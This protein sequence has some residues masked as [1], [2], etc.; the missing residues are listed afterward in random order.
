VA[1]GHSILIAP[2]YGSR[3]KIE[4]TLE[5]VDDIEDVAR[6]SEKTDVVAVSETARIRR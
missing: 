1:D 6:I 4:M 3:I 5:N 2:F